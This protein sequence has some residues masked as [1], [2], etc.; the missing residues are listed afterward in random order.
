MDNIHPMNSKLADQSTSEIVTATSENKNNS[1]DIFDHCIPVLSGSNKVSDVRDVKKENIEFKHRVS[2]ARTALIEGI[3]KDLK[4]KKEE[5]KIIK[6]KMKQL[7]T[8]IVKYNND[9]SSLKNERLK[10]PSNSS[11]DSQIKDINEIVKQVEEELDE[12]RV[13]IN[14]CI[15]EINNLEVEKTCIDNKAAVV[16]A[17]ENQRA[18]KMIVELSVKDKLKKRAEKKCKK[19]DLKNDNKNKSEKEKEKNKTKEDSI[20]KSQEEAERAKIAKVK[21]EEEAERAKIAK[22]KAE[23]EAE[24]AKIAKVK[25]EEEA[26]QAKIAKVK[27]EEEAEQA[28]I[29]KVK[30]E[31][32]AEKAK[33][34]KVKAE[35]EAEKAKIAKV[36]VEEEAKEAKKTESY[37]IADAINNRIKEYN[38]EYVKIKE[39]IKLFEG[40]VERCEKEILS[41]KNKISNNHNLSSLDEEI[42][43]I[44]QK[45]SGINIQ[46]QKEKEYEDKLSLLIHNLKD[47]IKSVENKKSVMLVTKTPESTIAPEAEVT[48][49]ATE[50]E[51]TPKA[52]ETEVTPKA[53]ETEVTPKLQ[54]PR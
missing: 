3:E 51:V 15:A 34:V 30:A 25:A 22:V 16:L 8:V 33:I 52:T 45:V 48:P 37:R 31:E 10:N 1:V 18:E 7:E 39:K 35:E 6:R 4:E 20:A 9:L 14:K 21:A 47:E 41:L 49:E 40:E 50:T 11:I 26:E 24:Q 5:H 38:K 23:E 13:K 44:K 54:R 28:K 19:D 36:K 43:T 53:T 27:A 2:K 46:I 42:K 29:A 12:E 32:E 17:T